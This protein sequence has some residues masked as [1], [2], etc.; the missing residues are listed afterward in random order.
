L[1]SADLYGVTKELLAQELPTFGATVDL[2]DCVDLAAVEAAITPR[3]RAIFTESF[4]NPLLRVADLRAL[5]EIAH[6]RGILLVVDNTFLSPALLRPLEHGADLVVHSA[7]KYLSGHGNVLGGGVCGR[8]TM[9]GAVAGM[10]S[11]LGG[12]MSPFSAW[13]LLA[14]VKTLPLRVERHCAN[15]A[16]LAA[17]L[18][19]HPAVE[20]VH[21]PGLSS[22]P[23]H[24]VARR[25][26]GDRFGGMLS[27]AL[28]GGGGATARFLDALRLP[29]IAVS[30]GDPATL[31][32]PVAGSALIR[33]SVG[34]EDWADLEADFTHALGQL[35]RS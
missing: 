13:L 25:L 30:L 21:Y 29:T 18:A 16:A 14:G 22:H 15:A 34:L 26:V 7:T 31:I 12:T 1:A 3:T 24:E 5:G 33:L 17:L 19:A 32:W 2:V 23:Q 20:A 6:R 28:R 11:R 35:D 9:I 10:G 4:S 8:R 27:F